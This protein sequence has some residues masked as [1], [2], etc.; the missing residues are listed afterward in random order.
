MEIFMRIRKILNRKQFYE[1]FGTAMFARHT[2]QKPDGIHLALVT[3]QYYIARR[4]TVS[5]IIST[6]TLNLE[7]I[8]VNNSDHQRQTVTIDTAK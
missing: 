6:W 4:Y 5:I 7:S 8:H 1:F 3:N 2:Q